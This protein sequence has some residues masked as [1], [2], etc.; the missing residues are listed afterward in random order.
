MGDG[1]DALVVYHVTIYYS[2]VVSDFCLLE[3][4]EVGE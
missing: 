3:N 1:F 2:S 4:V